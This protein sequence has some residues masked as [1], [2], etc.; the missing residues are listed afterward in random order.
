GVRGAPVRAGSGRRLQRARR[1]RGRRPRARVVARGR[2]RRREALHGAED[3]GSPR[4]RGGP[5]G[6]A[7]LPR[8]AP[9]PLGP[10]SL[11]SGRAYRPFRSV[12]VANRGEIAL[13]IIRGLREAGMRSIAVASEPDR[14]APHALAA[15]QCVVIGE[16][17][18]LESYL[19]ADRVLSAARQTKA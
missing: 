1:G 13:R 6:D 5:G 15:D 9:G 17:P 12:L 4:V 7:R 11:G 10:M 8:E 16:G 19:A 18:A 3:R 14:L 2:V